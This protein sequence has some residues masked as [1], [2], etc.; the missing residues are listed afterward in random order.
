VTQSTISARIQELE[1]ILGVE[2]FDRSQRHVQL[3]MKGRELVAYAEQLTLLVAEAK[4]NVGSRRS[5]TGIVRVGVAELVAI[6]WLSK[7]AGLVRAEYPGIQLEFEVGLNPFLIDGLRSGNIDIAVIAGRLTDPT[8]EA[9][10]LGTVRFSW[11]ASSHL[12]IPDSLLDAGELRRWPVIYQG[13]ES[14]TNEIINQ[15]LGGVSNMRK[16][17]GT[18]C[19]SLGAITSLTLAGVGISF[20]PNSLCSALIEAGELKILLTD[21]PWFDMPFSVVHARQS[22]DSLFSD[23]AMLSVQASTFVRSSNS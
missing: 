9:M 18:S 3:T 11:M 22:S 16:R 14:Y 19:N 2:L 10:D 8:L 21:P 13:T 17:R 23:I 7:F 12:D 1:Q 20:L 4:R 15:L 5:L 6:T